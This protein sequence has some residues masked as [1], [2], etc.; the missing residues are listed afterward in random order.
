M[1]NEDLKRGRLF[2]ALWE[3][4]EKDCRKLRQLLKDLDDKGGLGAQT[5]GRIKQL[6][7]ETEM[8]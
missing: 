3:D 6:L 2:R 5:H 1:A 7:E 8:V 4:A